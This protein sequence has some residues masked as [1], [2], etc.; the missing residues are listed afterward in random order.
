MDSGV[1][2]YIVRNVAGWNVG[3]RTREESGLIECGVDELDK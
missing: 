3:M 2:G 1:N